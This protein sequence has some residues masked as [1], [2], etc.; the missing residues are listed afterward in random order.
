MNDEQT[1][2]RFETLLLP[3]AAESF[4][5][6]GYNVSRWERDGFEFWAVSDV[7]AEDLRAFAGLEMQQS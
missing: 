7:S 4:T 1:R 2:T 3:L 5:K 6:D